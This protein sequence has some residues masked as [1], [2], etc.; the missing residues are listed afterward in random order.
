MT[1]V[2]ALPVGTELVGDYRIGRVLGAGGFGITYLAQEIALGRSVTIK[3]YFP[4]DFASRAGGNDAVPRSE[5]CAGDYKWGLDRFIEEAQ[6]LA[7]FDHPNIVKVFRYF[8]AN[9]TGYMVL[10][11]EE[12]QSLKAWMKGLG[13]AAR[14]K[15]VDRILAPLLDALAYIHAAD[16]LHRD[17]APDNVI[18]RTDG[19]PM[20]ID[21]GSARGEIAQHTRT[22]SA[23]VKPGYSPYEQYAETGHRQGPWTDI[24]ALGATLYHLVCGKRPPDSPSRVVKDELVPA[25]DAALS[26]YRSGFLAAI[27]RAL[28]LE[29]TKRPQSI[30]SWRG[31]LLAPDPKKPGWISRTFGKSASEQPAPG[32]AAPHAAAPPPAA[33]A[34]PPPPDAPGN[35]GGILDFFDGLKKKVEPAPSIDV[36]ARAEPAPTEKLAPEPP[37]APRA[38]KR[39]AESKAKPDKPK[40]ARPVP[41]PHGRTW[42]P[43]AAHLAF[44]MLVASAALLYRDKVPRLEII[45]SSILSNGAKDRRIAA[46]VQGHKGGTTAVAFTDD[47]KSIATTG[48]DGTLKLWN[49]ATGSLVRTLELDNGPALSLALFGRRAVTGHGDGTVALWELDRADKVASFKRNGAQIWSVAFAGEPTRVIASGHDWAVSLWDARV[50]NAPVH[51]FEGHDNAVQAVAFSSRGP[52]VASGSADRTIKLWNLA[53]QSI[54]RTYRG[55]K[56]FVT[57]LAFSGDGKVLA[58]ASLDGGIRLWSTASGRLIRSWSGHSQ[59]IGGLAFA[60]TGEQLASA[61]DDSA[62]K[63]WDVRSGRIARTFGIGGAPAKALAYA[64]EGRRLAAAGDDGAVRIFEAPVAARSKDE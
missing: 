61:G 23:L 40:R 5:Q 32:Q 13:R 11:F 6:T 53:S 37:P 17:I 24:Y 4:S 52:Y 64:P 48:A 19:T 20:L 34:M 54:V 44:A 8:R 18:I 26:A 25:K 3:E 36:L 45:G 2:L 60:P 49:A 55:H 56:D 33:T 62:V 43:R 46:E 15:E 41:A 21:F 28:A 29:T 50:G 35:K 63:V 16:Y 57:A 12:G 39:K 7:R 42:R 30:A 51:V 31:D 59:R 27:D 58:S 47:G 1:N 14:Q 9:N 22:L 38:A 10:G